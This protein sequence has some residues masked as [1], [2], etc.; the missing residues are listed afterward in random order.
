MNVA[1]YA[2]T[3]PVN[4]FSL[5]HL[6]RCGASYG[7][8]PLRPLTHFAVYSSSSGPLLAY[9]ALSTNNL[10]LV[11]FDALNRASTISPLQYHP[12]T[13][14]TPH[15]LSIIS[16]VSSVLELTLRSNSTSTFAIHQIGVFAPICRL[17]NC[18]LVHSRARTLHSTA[19]SAAPAHIAP[20]EN[21]PTH[22]TLHL[23]APQPLPSGRSCHLTRSSFQSLHWANTHTKSSSWMSSQATSPSWA[24]RPNQ[25]QLCSRRYNT[26]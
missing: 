14:S 15:F 11:D 13:H 18:L 8:D 3:I 5:G 17:V 19:S 2:P 10:L 23:P 9:A 26:S 6:Q 22:L 7:P 21:T 25:L 12:P 1:Y 20:L 16:T 4:L 24:Q